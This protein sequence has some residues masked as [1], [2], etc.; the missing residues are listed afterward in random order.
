MMIIKH[1]FILLA[2]L[3]ICAAT[4]AL[5]QDMSSGIS[6]D[7]APVDIIPAAS[8]SSEPSAIET[9]G[10]THPPVRLTPDKSELIRLDKKA[11]TIIVGNPEHVSVL[12][13]SAQALVLVPRLPGATHVTVL[14]QFGE[15]LM[16]RHVIVASPQKKYVRIRKSCAGSDDDT[17]Q[18]TQVYYCPDMCHE[19]SM[20]VQ[21]SGSASMPAADLENLT[22]ATT[23]EDVDPEAVEE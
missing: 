13:E 4:P 3:L 21:D 11:G 6:D 10:P 12:A 22:Q 5:A 18:A 19:I 15:V 23:G 17:C 8:L 1:T 16:S 9:N 2:A 20:A 7:N 14:D